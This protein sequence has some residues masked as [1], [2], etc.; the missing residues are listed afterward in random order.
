MFNKTS[1]MGEGPVGVCLESVDE[2]EEVEGEMR[3]LPSYGG[4]G[5]ID[6]LFPLNF[7]PCRATVGRSHT[8]LV[9]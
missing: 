8:G 9:K 4:E 1:G 2:Q 5:Q 6:C 7:M 3:D